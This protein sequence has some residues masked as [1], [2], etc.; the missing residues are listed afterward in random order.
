MRHLLIA[1]T[2][3]AATTVEAKE[4][5]VNKESCSQANVYCDIQSAINAA[6]PDDVVTLKAGEYELWQE[7][8]A[9]DKSLTLQ[10]ESA[11][12]TVLLGEG[13]APEALI[14]ISSDAEQVVLKR[15]T[16]QN[17]IVAGSPAMGPGGLDH[18]GGDLMLDGVVFQGNRGGWGGAV[19]IDTLFGTVDI[20]NSRFVGNTGF[21][22]GGIAVY[23]GSAL[24][25]SIVNTE[26]RNNNAI[27]SGGAFLMRDVADAVLQNLT[28][29]ENS[30]G[31][32]GGGGHVFTDVGS[33]QVII[34]D[35]TFSANDAARVGGLSSFG[36]NVSLELVNSTLTENL[37][38]NSELQPDCAGVGIVVGKLTTL[39]Q[40]G[41]CATKE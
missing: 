24:E 37:S 38:R 39:T 26:F 29:V 35:S 33:T 30:A 6:K 34:E 15:L 13:K 23:N 18:K 5:T 36:S 22:G 1:I 31:N 25:L 32:T 16:I 7:S 11:E 40:T 20:Q 27:F 41:S 17:R 12:N 8:I 10:G 19:R 28:V 2:L 14:N 21:A 4:I 9:I 3:S